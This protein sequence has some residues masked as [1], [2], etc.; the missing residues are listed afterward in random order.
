[1][2]AKVTVAYQAEQQFGGLSQQQR[3]NLIH[4]VTGPAPSANTRL[5]EPGKFVSRIAPDMRVYW[6]KHDDEGINV[7]SI[8]RRAA[9]QA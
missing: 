3:D 7:L 9:H 8:V 4:T 2:T 6:S 1:M 5:V